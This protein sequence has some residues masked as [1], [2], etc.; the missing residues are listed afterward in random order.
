MVFLVL[1][2]FHVE[3]HNTNNFIES[4]KR[5]AVSYNIILGRFANTFWNLSIT[6]WKFENLYVQNNSKIF[7]ASN[8]ISSNFWFLLLFIACAILC[9]WI[10]IKISFSN[11]SVTSKLKSSVDLL[12]LVRLATSGFKVK[13]LYSNWE[14]SGTFHVSLFCSNSVLMLLFDD[15][16]WS[17]LRVDGRSFSLSRT[18]VFYV[19]AKT[20]VLPWDHI[21]FYRIY[22]CCSTAMF[23]KTN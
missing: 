20:L 8:V 21:L 22:S 7:M 10:Y 14:S 2:Y 9:N 17:V 23:L 11:S 3:M 16:P 13:F 19:E 6:V 1:L 4:V 5:H 12:N 18:Q 15:S